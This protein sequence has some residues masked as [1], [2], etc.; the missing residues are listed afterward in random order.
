MTS[1]VNQKQ[2]TKTY[3]SKPGMVK[4]NPFEFDPKT[5]EKL[6]KEH[7]AVDPTQDMKAAKKARTAIKKMITSVKKVH[8]S[9]KKLILNFKRDLEAWDKGKFEQLTD[10]LVELHNKLDSK[11]KDIEGGEA[12]RVA[13]LENKVTSLNLKFSNAILNASTTEE[14]Q[15]VQVELN[16]FKPD[17]NEWQEK[18]GDVEHIKTTM[19]IKAS[20]RATE[21][22]NAGGKIQNVEAI[23]P[24]IDS[25]KIHGLNDTE[26]I[27]FLEA[28]AI[29]GQGWQVNV[30]AH[31]GVSIYQVDDKKAPRSLRQAIKEAMDQH[32]TN[33]I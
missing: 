30:S 4:L 18:F 25:S 11:I 20:G 24:E 7:S 26:L 31:T 6:I 14:I 1:S 13:D 32:K 29:M 10:G 22:Q 17:K 16:D 12:K 23:P 19:I 21:I 8:T 27:N 5:I 9:N 2:T 33:T 3:P 28:N 15:A